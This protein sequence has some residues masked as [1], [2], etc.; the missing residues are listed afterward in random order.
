[1]ADDQ[2]LCGLCHDLSLHASAMML[3]FLS[4][5]KAPYVPTASFLAMRD[6][7]L[8]TALMGHHSAA[9]GI[10]AQ[11]PDS[12]GLTDHTGLKVPRHR[13]D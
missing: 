11:Q 8:Q 12:P 10:A 2:G 3:S 6:E 9:W 7:L 13:L 4:P 5:T 1:M